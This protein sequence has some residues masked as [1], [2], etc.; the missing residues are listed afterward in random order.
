MYSFV[1]CD[2]AAPEGAVFTVD[3]DVDADAATR[4]N[5]DS[6]PHRFL[7]KPEPIRYGPWQ[8]I[9]RGWRGPIEKVPGVTGYVPEYPT[10]TP[11]DPLPSSIDIATV[12]Q[13]RLW[14]DPRQCLKGRRWSGPGTGTGEDGMD[15]YIAYYAGPNWSAAVSISQMHSR[16]RIR[17]VITGGNTGVIETLETRRADRPGA[18]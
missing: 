16:P 6:S 3:S 11:P 13:H 18:V 7:G 14:R 12:K 17:Y 1:G 4:F 8:L 15:G 9:G 10:T 5:L 2:G